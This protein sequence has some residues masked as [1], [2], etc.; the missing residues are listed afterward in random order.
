VA[1]IGLYSGFLATTVTWITTVIVPL[2]VVGYAAYQ[3]ASVATIL[4]CVAGLPIS[5]FTGVQVYGIKRG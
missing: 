1:W 4:A 2:A 5:L 3:Q